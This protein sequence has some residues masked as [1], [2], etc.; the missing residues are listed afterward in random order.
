MRPAKHDVLFEPIRI[1]PKVLKNR[2]V[3]TPQCNG[4]GSDFRPAMQAGHRGMKA[5]GGWA[6]ICTEAC[7]I[8]PETDVTGYS[9]P[10]SRLWDDGDIQNLSAMCAEV[11]RHDAL[12]GVELF[13]SYRV[14]S[15]E[16]RMV[17][18]AASS[19]PTTTATSVYGRYASVDQ[20]KRVQDLYVAAS[21][22]ALE[23]GFDYVY[24]YG[25]H[26]ELPGAFLS[27]LRNTRTD[28]YGGSFANRSRFWRETIEK[29]REAVGDELAIGARMAIDTLE[30]PGGTETNGDGV[31]FV[32][33]VDHLVDFWDLTIGTQ[34]WGD[35]AGPSRFFETNHQAP[36]AAAVKAG[37]YTDKP[38][39]G[40]GRFTDP[41]VMVEAIE[42]GLYDIIGAAR[43]SIADPFLPKKIEEGRVEDIR[44]CI[45][46]NECVA[47]WEVGGPIVCSQN[48][49]A[50]EEYRRGWHPER[51]TPAANR[52]KSV[53][54]VGA[55]PAGLECAVV[56]GKR[57]MSAVHLIDSGQEIGGS[58]NWITKLGHS[59]GQPNLHLGQARGLGEWRRVVNYR[60]I[61]LSKLKNVEV[62][63]RTELSTDDVFEYGADLVV[64]ATGCDY[65]TD[66]LNGVTFRP[67]PGADATTDWQLT[68]KDVALGTKP[69]GGRVLVYDTERNY[70]GVTLAQQLAGLGLQVTLV[71]DAGEFGGYMKYTLEQDFI[72]RDLTRMRVTMRAATTVESIEPGAVHLANYW[73]PTLKD[74]V[75]IDSV[76][77]CTQRAPRDYLYRALIDDVERMHENEIEG[78][79]VIGDA[80]APRSLPDVVF[81][82]HRLAREI[83]SPDPGTPLP[84]I[85]ERPLWEGGPIS[86][87]A[88]TAAPAVR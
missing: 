39:L 4:A 80:A 72:V 15:M 63:T 55:G 51:F 10:I 76:V 48:A 11:H 58:L 22:R 23:A 54:V 60:Q 70:M 8:A 41:D 68:P 35:N 28:E 74:T 59:D 75:E 7:S 12:A 45:G 40:V 9:G 73:D 24:V 71:T 26:M 47:R 29:V 19:F 1:G 84:F 42:S 30:G 18:W 57:G 49:T 6:G 33:H 21:L 83:D 62:H 25:A 34:D 65:V 77:L 27:P 52:E 20:I 69:V 53:V 17:P 56:L 44:E 79:W 14:P 5:E 31:R 66:G 64:I 61:Q 67:I 32:E 88:G 37:N 3:Q 78:V 2:F 82:G 50:G 16:S 85:R 46:C 81:D 36:F 86:S 38:V 13:Y 87:E 43:P